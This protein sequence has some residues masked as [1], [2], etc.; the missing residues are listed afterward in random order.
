MRILHP[1]LTGGKSE[2]AKYDEASKRLALI[3]VARN[4]KVQ[5]PTPGRQD[6]YCHK[7]GGY[8]MHRAHLCGALK[9]IFTQQHDG[10]IAENPDEL[11]VF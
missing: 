1:R 10:A 9:A 3:P 8:P 4:N 11:R 7:P 6:G 2:P 5:R